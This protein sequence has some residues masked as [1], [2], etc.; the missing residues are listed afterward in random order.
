MNPNL[1]KDLYL[2]TDPVKNRYG[3][4]VNQYA[5]LEFIVAIIVSLVTMLIVSF[6]FF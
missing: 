4:F 5:A 1:Y 6:I 2:Y 3:I